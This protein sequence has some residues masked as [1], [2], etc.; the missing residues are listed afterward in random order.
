[1]IRRVRVL[2]VDD[3]AAMR[4]LISA[5]MRRDA[6][7]EVIGE[8]T[9]PLEARQAIKDLQPDVITLDVEMPK[10]NGLEFLDRIMRLRPTPVIMISNLTQRGAQETIRALEIGAVD[11]M[12]KPSPGN[13]NS[14]EQLPVRVKMAAKAKLRGA[15]GSTNGSN[16]VNGTTNDKPAMSYKPARS[17]VVIGSSTGGVEALSTILTAF[18]ANCPPTVIAQHMPE[19]F[20]ASLAARLDKRFSPEIAVATD[21]A[22]LLP[23][24]VYFAPGGRRHTEIVEGAIRRLRVREGDVINGYC[25]SIDL[26]FHSAGRA[27]SGNMV[28]V[29]LTGMGR[30][31]A[32]GL[33]AMRRAGARTLGQDE[34]TSLIYGM[35][36]AAFENGAVERQVPLANIAAEILGMTRQKQEGTN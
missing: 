32:D 9:D 30:D 8:A 22:Q 7:I 29:I 19:S 13:L 17:I 25:P 5:I 21:G 16:G 2:I 3:S 6:D 36:K 33:L 35:P 27:Q 31:G 15:L 23:G 20:L 4:G 24:R 26:L 11:C 34:A 18:P 28:G 12:A 10:M 14:L 1:M